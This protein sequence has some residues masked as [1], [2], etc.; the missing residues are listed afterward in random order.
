[1]S[2]R[3]ARAAMF[4]GLVLPVEKHLPMHLVLRCRSS[5]K[6]YLAPNSLQKLLRDGLHFPSTSCVHLG[7]LLCG[8]D[9]RTTVHEGNADF[10][11]VS[12]SWCIHTYIQVT[13]FNYL[14]QYVMTCG[15]MADEI[16]QDKCFPWRQSVMGIHRRHTMRLRIVM[17]RIHRWVD[18]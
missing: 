17:R 18:A 14:L 9:L 16:K 12:M 15:L 2:T 1:M 4:N 6:A 11:V 3:Y 13:A 8:N 10:D 7:A 5:S